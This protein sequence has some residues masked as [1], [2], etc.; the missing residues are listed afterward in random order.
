MIG[1]GRQRFLDCICKTFYI[2]SQG[3]PISAVR[4]PP[5]RKKRAEAIV[6]FRSD[7]PEDR[8]NQT[9]DAWRIQSGGPPRNHHRPG[10]QTGASPEPSPRRPHR[11]RFRPHAIRPPTT[12]HFAVN[13]FVPEIA[14]DHGLGPPRQSS[15]RHPR[16]AIRRGIP[17]VGRN[18]GGPFASPGLSWPESIWRLG[19]RQPL[20][21]SPASMK[22]ILFETHQGGM[23]C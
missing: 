13:P 1:G 7:H 21:I 23:T 2:S 20:K 12:D 9:D 16:A 11:P 8:W 5:N 14:Y 6:V 18:A 4:T 10:I 17:E 19:G 3:N 22:R 15:G